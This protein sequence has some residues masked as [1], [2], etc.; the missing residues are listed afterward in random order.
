MTEIHPIVL[1][2][3]GSAIADP[4]VHTEHDVGVHT[5]R[6]QF[7]PD[8]VVTTEGIRG[9]ERQPV[10]PYRTAL[11]SGFGPRTFENAVASATHSRT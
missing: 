11:P 1:H 2:P 4:D 7:S 6:E 9:A 3:N 5:G 8:P 10:Q